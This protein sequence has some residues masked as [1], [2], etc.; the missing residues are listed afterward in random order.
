MLAAD[1]GTV[2]YL[3][4][5]VDSAPPLRFCQA[6]LNLDGPVLTS[7]TS[8]ARNAVMRRGSVFVNVRLCGL[9]QVKLLPDLF[10]KVGLC[11]VGF[12]ES[13]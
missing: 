10:F 7:Y 8:G 12:L 3:N 1:L 13:L 6:H 9:N 5:L 11:C 2:T 4:P